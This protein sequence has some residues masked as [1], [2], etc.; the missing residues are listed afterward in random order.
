MCWCTHSLNDHGSFKYWFV[1]IGWNFVSKQCSYYFSKKR[2]ETFAS[3]LMTVLLLL[4]PSDVVRSEN[5]LR[6]LRL[7]MCGV[8]LPQSPGL[9]YLAFRV[10]YAAYW[11]TNGCSSCKLY[12]P[13][14]GRSYATTRSRAGLL[15]IH[16]TFVVHHLQS[17]RHGRIGTILPVGSAQLLFF[18]LLL[19]FVFFSFFVATLCELDC[20]TAE[21]ACTSARVASTGASIK[22]LTY[23]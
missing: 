17:R 19:S 14:C 1:F 21:Q 6:H 12:A 23:N 11:F 10:R 16:L 18:F 20:S 4:S 7:T 15:P 22:M 5:T 3:V 8:N 9:G 2:K 13:Q